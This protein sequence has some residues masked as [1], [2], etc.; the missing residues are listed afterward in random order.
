ML[1][2]GSILLCILAINNKYF[3]LGEEEEGDEIPLFSTSTDLYD[4]SVFSSDFSPFIDPE[5]LDGTTLQTDQYLAEQTSIFGFLNDDTN[6]ENG[7]A[8][9]SIF[10]NSNENEAGCS[11]GSIQLTDSIALSRRG[12][13]NAG[14]VN[15]DAGS[16]GSSSSS[17]STG[18]I[19]PTS[20]D[21]KVAPFLDVGTMELKR[22]CPRTDLIPFSLAV[23]SSGVQ[24]DIVIRPPKLSYELNWAQKSK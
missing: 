8:A 11:F 22:I 17:S 16:G 6:V 15:P 13:V 1:S 20:I 23:C 14:C 18:L 21:P 9:L 7:D 5:A 4:P 19:T 10:A 24:G 3:A 2:V 12:A